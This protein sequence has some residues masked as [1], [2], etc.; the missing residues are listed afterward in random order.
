MPEIFNP[1]R[2]AK[3]SLLLYG[4]MLFTVWFNLW[5]ARL[6]LAHLGAEGYG[7]YGVVAGVVGIF[8]FFTMGIT[9]SVQRFITF[10][11]G[12]PNGNPGRMFAASLF[13]VLML[14]A[15]MVVVLE[16][17]GVC[18]A[19]YAINIPVAME[20]AVMPVYQLSVLACVLTL[21]AVPFHAVVIAHERMDIYAMVTIAQVV[22]S[23]LAAYVLVQWP[24]EERLGLY[25]VFMAMVPLVVL[26]AYIG[27]CRRKFE[28]TR[29][30][31]RLEM[32][33][34]R[35]IATFAGVS[36]TSGLLQTL[37]FHGIVLV[38][39]WVFGVTVNAVYQIALQLKNS[40]LSFGLNIFKAISPQITK[41]YADGDIDRHTRLVYTGSKVEAYMIL[42]ILIPFVCRAEQIM[43]L[44]L[45][46]LPPYT[47]AF[48]V[49]TVFLSLTYAFFEPIRASVLATNRITKFLL[50]PDSLYLLAIPISYGVSVLTNDPRMM[51]V[52]VVLTDILICVVRV[53]YAAQVTSVRMGVLLRKVLV[54][55]CAV[56]ILSGALCA[57]LSYGL[58][59]D[60]LGLLV[61]LVANSLLMVVVIYL[62]GLDKDERRI[63][64]GF[65][66]LKVHG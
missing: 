38:V 54:P 64:K 41:T 66:R 63:V 16:T 33:V 1:Q 47:V 24:Q 19:L 20:P 22:L 14:A 27:Y 42:L 25:A 65:L 49:C 36:T 59:Q 45:G 53:W 39:N 4:R 5:A 60:V 9:S 37:A 35:E 46:Y 8:S 15:L 17:A 50:V 48:A 31:L 29:V 43:T 12:K 62:V 55:C 10:E 56:G 58:K 51:I 32:G 34:V 61:L 18:F 6:V 3:N 40:V 28:E 44:W 52:S 57:A 7:V 11:L 23:W 26:V 2:I 30:R 13:A 21:L